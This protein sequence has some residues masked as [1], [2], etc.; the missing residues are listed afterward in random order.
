MEQIT[1]D[2]I[3]KTCSFLDWVFIHAI[4]LKEAASKI[5]NF[6]ADTYDI[7]FTVN[8]V[9]LPIIKTFQNLGKQDERRIQEAAKKLVEE[10]FAD[11]DND[12][13]DIFEDVKNTYLEKLK[14][15]S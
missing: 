6:H 9:E 14:K 3:R 10:K 13:S 11:L 7:S 5:K 12:L 4:T 8:G 15:A 2:E 1:Y